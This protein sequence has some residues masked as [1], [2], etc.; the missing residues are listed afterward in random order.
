MAIVGFFAV[1]LYQPAGRAPEA[2]A[3]EGSARIS[4]VLPGPAPIRLTRARRP[5]AKT[6]SLGGR[7]PLEFTVVEQGETLVDVAR[8]VY[9]RGEAAPVIAR[10][11]RDVLPREGAALEPG[12]LLRTPPLEPD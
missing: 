1:A 10:A 3:H 7:G 2:K 12:E 8:R 9:G 6:D 5:V 4:R 11:N